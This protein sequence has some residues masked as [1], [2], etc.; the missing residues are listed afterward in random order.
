LQTDLRGLVSLEYNYFEQRTIEIAAGSSTGVVDSM[1][2]Q[3][4][5]KSQL[6]KARPAST[7]LDLTTE[8]ADELWSDV[9]HSLW[10][11]LSTHGMNC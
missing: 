5:G 4:F 2:Y 6:F 11:G 10:S 3:R 7:V 1:A 9:G 8:D